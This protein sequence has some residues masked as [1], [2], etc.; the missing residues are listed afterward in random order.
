M[1]KK[2]ITAFIVFY[3]GIV[4]AILFMQF[5]VQERYGRNPN[6]VRSEAPSHAGRITLVQPDVYDTPAKPYPVPCA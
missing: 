3:I 2:R 6:R 4:L 1:T 5:Y